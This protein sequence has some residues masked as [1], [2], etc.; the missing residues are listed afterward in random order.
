MK[1]ALGRIISML[2]VILLA[3]GY[4]FSAT[5]FVS[6]EFPKDKDFIL[7]CAGGYRSMIAASILKSRGYHNFKDVIGGMGDLTKTSIPKTEYVC[8][9]TLL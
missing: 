1:I 4:Y 2:A 8:P 9:K 7:H 6:S 5:H 3:F